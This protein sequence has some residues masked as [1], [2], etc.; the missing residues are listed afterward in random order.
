MRYPSIEVIIPLA[1][2]AALSP[3]SPA[4]AEGQDAFERK[5]TL[6]LGQ[7]AVRLGE[8]ESRYG[9]TRQG[10]ID[11]DGNT[12]VFGREDTYQSLTT[13]NGIDLPK[14]GATVGVG[15]GFTF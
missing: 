7:V 4:Q 14:T 1:M 6:Y 3:W 5:E 8:D 10:N 15:M 9:S 2:M 12:F 11:L 13:L